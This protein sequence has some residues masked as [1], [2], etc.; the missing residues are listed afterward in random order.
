MCYFFVVTLFT[1]GDYIQDIDVNQLAYCMVHCVSQPPPFYPYEFK[2]LAD[3]VLSY[4]NITRD[5]I[6]AENCKVVYCFC[7]YELSKLE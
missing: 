7:A 3:Q 4:L 2:L 6:T 5:E 1:G